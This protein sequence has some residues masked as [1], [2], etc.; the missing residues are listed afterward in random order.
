MLPEPTVRADAVDHYAALLADNGWPDEM[1]CLTVVRGLSVEEA[2]VR[3]D[4]VAT[5]R[6]ATLVDAGRAAMSAFP[7]DLRL[8]VADVLDGWV[9][10]AEH[11]GYHGSMPEV[12]SRLSAGTVAAS[13]YW[14]VN[15]VS[16]ITLAHDGAVVDD[17]DPVTDEP[18]AEGALEPFVRGL[19]FEELTC[20]SALAVLERVSG[21]R[22]PIEWASRPHPASVIGG[23]PWLDLSDPVKWVEVGAPGLHAA[24]ST[25]GGAQLRSAATL[26]VTSACETAGVDDPVVLDS[27]ARDA[28]SLSAAER[29]DLRER[30]ANR[31]Q[32][33]YRQA[34]TLR[35]DRCRTSASSDLPTEHGLVSRAHAMAAAH[36]RLVDDA[37]VGLSLAVANA[38]QIDKT[39]W[40]DLRDRLAQAL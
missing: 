6:E 9:V 7:E 34:L 10:L 15:M 21:V 3:F 4:G 12:L 25:A 23:F 14:N 16:Q 36:G 5:G 22:V 37:R 35:W 24:L 20:E 30:L 11:N 32:E 38:C 39:T 18:P 17:F 8:V 13:A 2:L 40:P 28:D 33:A 19:D 27:L 31:A 29:T 26:A 1:M